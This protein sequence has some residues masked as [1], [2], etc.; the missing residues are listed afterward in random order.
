MHLARC[1]ERL[2]RAL[3]DPLRADVDPAS[4]AVIWPNIVSPSAS[5]RR[6]SSQVA[7]RGTSS[8]FA[9]STRGAA[10]CVRKTPTGLPD[11]D[12]QRLVVAKPEQRADDRPQRLVR[13]RAARPEPP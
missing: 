7:Q 3:Q 5:S 11:L 4:P 2:V 13:L 10:S 6:N 8:E 9:I 12:E 1:G